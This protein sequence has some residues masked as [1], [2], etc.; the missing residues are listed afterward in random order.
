MLAFSGDVYNVGPLK[1]FRPNGVGVLHGEDCDFEIKVLG[2]KVNLIK[3]EPDKKLSG[4]N[5]IAENKEQQHVPPAR[6]HASKENERE[7]NETQ[8]T[9]PDARSTPE[10][11]T[12]KDMEPKVKKSSFG[13]KS[14]S[15]T[16]D[17]SQTIEKHMP[18]GGNLVVKTNTETIS[19]S[20]KGNNCKA[21]VRVSEGKLVEMR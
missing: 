16:G 10:N 11:T 19:V 4:K 3:L 7:D 8:S 18:G 15:N 5:T 2:D 21:T 17:S 1:S 13:H 20:M 9:T 6:E 12:T 14:K